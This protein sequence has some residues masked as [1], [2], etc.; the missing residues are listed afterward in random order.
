MLGTWSDSCLTPQAVDLY[1]L[2]RAFSST[3]PQSEELFHRIIKAYDESDK[4]GSAAH[5]LKKLEDVRSRGR[6]RTMLG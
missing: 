3:H 4:S 6:K 2:E 1:V 5:V